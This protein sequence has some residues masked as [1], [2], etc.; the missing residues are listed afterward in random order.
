[1]HNNLVRAV[2]T[3]RDKFKFNL[4][5]A[6]PFYFVLLKRL[7]CLSDLGGGAIQYLACGFDR[8][9]RVEFKCI[10]LNAWKD[11]H[12]YVKNILKCGL[13][14]SQK[15]INALT[16]HTRAPDRLGHLHGNFE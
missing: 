15:Q 6:C 5:F 4:W 10:S 7:M 1:M 14:I 12:M 16:A 9:V 2:E 11:M 3:T 13:S 8:P